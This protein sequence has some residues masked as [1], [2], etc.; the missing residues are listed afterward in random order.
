MR[1][2]LPNR[3]A[4]QTT[5]AGAALN[6]R[7]IGFGAPRHRVPCKS[8]N[9]TPDRNLTH[10][11]SHCRDSS[12]LDVGILACGLRRFSGSSR[13]NESMNVE[14]LEGFARSALALALLASYK[15]GS[16]GGL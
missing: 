7:A 8:A 15:I 13:R 10:S 4:N 5:V 2:R 16:D 11:L 1:G 12:S 9:R 6:V 14:G 3:V